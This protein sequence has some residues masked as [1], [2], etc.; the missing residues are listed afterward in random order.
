[1][2]GTIAALATADRLARQLDLSLTLLVPQVVPYRIPITRPAV[3]ID[4]TRRAVLSMISASVVNAHAISVQICFC[5]DRIECLT[6]WLGAG[7]IVLL[8]GR[9]Y[10]WRRRER[11]LGRVLRAMGCEVV[12]A[13]Q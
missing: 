13:D 12:F 1:M 6:R 9:N 2:R 8:G 4:H 10:W 5:R 7:S 11:R 3:A